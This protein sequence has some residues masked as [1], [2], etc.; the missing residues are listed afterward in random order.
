MI[1]DF[2]SSVREPKEPIQRQFQEE[3]GLPGDI[4]PLWNRV[5][6][7]NKENRIKGVTSYTLIF[8]VFSTRQTIGPDKYLPSQRLFGSRISKVE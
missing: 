1:T 3:E 6:T 4:Q 8:Y 7:G 2:D 5:E